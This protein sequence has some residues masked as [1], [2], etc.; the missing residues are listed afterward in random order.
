MGKNEG[1]KEEQEKPCKSPALHS[2]HKPGARK[3]VT[4]RRE[5]KKG[6]V[7]KNKTPEKGMN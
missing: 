7:R 1:K 4:T 6:K 5:E 2:W 3:K